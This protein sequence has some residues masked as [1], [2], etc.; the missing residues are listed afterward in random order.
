[1]VVNTTRQT[2]DQLLDEAR[3]R[4]DRYEPRA[5]FSAVERGALIIDIR[6]VVDR[7]RDGIMPVS[8]H[9]PLD[10]A[11]VATRPRQR[12][13]QPAPRRRRSG[14]RA[15]LR[16]RLLL[17]ARGRDLGRPRLHARRRHRRWLRSV[18]RSGAPD[19]ATKHPSPRSRR[20]AWHAT[21]RPVARSARYRVC[22]RHVGIRERCVDRKMHRRFRAGVPVP[23]RH[24]GGECHERPRI[25]LVL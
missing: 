22:E 25:R 13:A 20:A 10:R 24:S 2:L 23:V 17:V 18:A 4:V 6:S 12:M 15:R 5:A 14:D 21:T 9:I 19:G 1:M 3:A 11:R 16:P 8:L 7:E